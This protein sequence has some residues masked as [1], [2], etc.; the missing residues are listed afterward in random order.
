MKIKQVNIG[1]EIKKVVDIKMGNKSHFGRMIGKS[2][3]NVNSQ[4]FKKASIDT[5]LLSKISE[6]LDFNF[7]SLYFDTTK[8]V[9]KNNDKPKIHATLEIDLT[10][11]DIIKL[12]LSEKIIKQLKN[13]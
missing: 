5:A 12:G 1:V 8:N 4:I 13:K 6:V 2:R 7:F 10:E 3:Q 9:V 11:E